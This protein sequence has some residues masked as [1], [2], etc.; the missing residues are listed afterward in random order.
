MKQGERSLS[1]LYSVV[2]GLFLSGRRKLSKIGRLRYC[3]DTDA[4]VESLSLS[5]IVIVNIIR[6]EFCNIK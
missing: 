2:S 6:D 4:L 3:V 1:L 5:T